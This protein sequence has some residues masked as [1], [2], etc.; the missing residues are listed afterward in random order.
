[1]GKPLKDFIVDF[2]LGGLIIAVSGYYI[3]MSESRI[4]G[5]IYGALPIGFI[6]LYLLTYYVDGKSA[7]QKVAREVTIASIFF[8]L[9]VISTHLFT[10]YGVWLALVSNDLLWVLMVFLSCSMISRSRSDRP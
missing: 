1:M 8:I 6:Y 5:F 9:F 4:G 3:R 7:C 2:V 10:P